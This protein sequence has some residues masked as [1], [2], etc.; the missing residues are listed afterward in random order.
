VRTPGWLVWTARSLGYTVYQEARYLIESLQY[1][2]RLL[3][4]GRVLEGDALRGFLYLA[5]G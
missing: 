2:C 4:G 3:M 5:G 1:R